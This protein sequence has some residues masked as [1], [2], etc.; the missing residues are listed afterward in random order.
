MKILLIKKLYKKFNIILQNYKTFKA[1][2]KLIINIKK[3]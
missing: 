1:K 3:I 2:A